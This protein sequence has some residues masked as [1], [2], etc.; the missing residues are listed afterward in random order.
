[1]V[2]NIVIMAHHTNGSSRRSLLA[3]LTLLVLLDVIVVGGSTA[4]NPES[5]LKRNK[6]QQSPQSLTI[7]I[8][9][10]DD[11]TRR[12]H[13]RQRQLATST[14][15]KPQE[16]ASMY[17]DDGEHYIDLW[18]GSPKPQ[19]QT[20]LVVTGVSPGI[21]GFPCSDCVGE[22]GKY[23]HIDKLY[24][25]TKSKT[26]KVLDCNEC[27]TG[28]CPTGGNGDKGDNDKKCSSGMSYPSGDY[29]RGYEVSDKCYLGGPH[30]EPVILDKDWDGYD[31]ID[32]KKAA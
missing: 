19:R 10:T 1:M 24:Q 31:D 12:R 6:K 11:A 25:N 13:Q 5:P 16:L 30:D 23:T 32:F 22:C 4:T 2:P 26:F 21:S 18:C 17:Q 15:G 9:K 29:W 7:P 14:L 20:L 28:S 27:L 3:T 8:R